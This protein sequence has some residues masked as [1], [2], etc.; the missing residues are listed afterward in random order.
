VLASI[1]SE[2]RIFEAW[3]D[4]P[5][6]N[7]G[8]S[9]RVSLVAFGKSQQPSRLDGSVVGTFHVDLK[10]SDGVGSEMDVTVARELEANEGASFFGYC[11]SGPFAVT[12]DTARRWLIEPNPHGLPNARVLSPIWNGTELMKR[13]GERWVVD[14]GASMSA[15]DAALFEA[16]YAHVRSQVLPKRTKNREASRVSRWWLH[17]RPR[18][19]LRRATQGLTRWIVTSETSRHRVFVWMP[20]GISP[21]HKLVT[22]TRSDDRMLVY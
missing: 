18:P 19:E 10:S 1:V 4:E 12:A 8:A 17:G 14:F 2:T 5:W 6:I 9:V 22:V 13:L 11:L 15:Q 16:P 7:D 20:A 21:E 3:A